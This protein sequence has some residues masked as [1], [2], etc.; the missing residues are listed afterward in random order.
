MFPDTFGELPLT[1]VLSSRYSGIRGAI[2][3]MAKTNAIL[4]RS[5]NKLYPIENTYREPIKRLW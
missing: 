1:G 4:K 5:L 2:M 3:R